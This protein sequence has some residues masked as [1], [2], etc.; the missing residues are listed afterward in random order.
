[1]KVS[2][3]EM[4]AALF[5]LCLALVFHE[6]L[7]APYPLAYDVESD[8]PAEDGRKRVKRQWGWGGPWGYRPWGFRPW[9]Y[10]PWGFRPW[11]FRP[12]GGGFCWC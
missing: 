8:H 10:R 11:G 7:C 5:L 3:R 6:S 9:G 12:W 1:M 4:R 2:R